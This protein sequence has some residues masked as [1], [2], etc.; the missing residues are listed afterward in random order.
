[1]SMKSMP[2]NN[3]PLPE[4]KSLGDQ[5]AFKSNKKDFKQNHIGQNNQNTSPTNTEKTSKSCVI[6]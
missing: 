5:I 4:I 3:E 6:L 1:M 2:N